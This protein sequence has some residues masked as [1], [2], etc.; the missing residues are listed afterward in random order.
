MSRIPDN[1][2]LRDM[3]TMPMHMVEH[4]ERVGIN[5]VGDLMSAAE[6]ITIGEL[7]HRIGEIVWTASAFTLPWMEC[8]GVLNRLQ[9][10]LVIQRKESAV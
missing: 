9:T 2:R 5:S 6:E 7:R 3:D 10:G 8:L 1:T 4:L